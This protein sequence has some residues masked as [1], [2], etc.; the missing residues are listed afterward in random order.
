MNAIAFFSVYFDKDMC[1]RLLNDLGSKIDQ[2]RMAIIW[3]KGT[4]P[5]S[6]SFEK[7]RERYLINLLESGL[8][9]KDISLKCQYFGANY[10]KISN[11]AEIEKEL[12]EKFA[13]LGN[14]EERKT[15]NAKERAEKNRRTSEYNKWLDSLTQDENKLV[16]Y[17]Q[18][19]IELRDTRKD[20]IA[21]FL[22]VVFK[23][24]QKLFREVGMDEKLIYFYMFNEIIR[25]KKYLLENKD[26]LMKRLDGC[27]VFVGYNGLTEIEYGTFETTKS[28]LD[29]FFL[30]Q[31][32][33]F[34][35]SEVIKGQV[36]APGKIKGI[37]KV[38]M[39]LSKESE[40][41]NDGDI[42]VT[43]MTRPEFVPLMK[44]AAAIVTDEGGITCHAAIVSRE[45]GIPC[46][47]GTKVASRLLKDG[48]VI[49]VDAN[50]G[51][52]RILK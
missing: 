4:T 38:V 34:G 45:L 16:R 44:K 50:T 48:D 28:K 5:V 18:K 30:E 12:K 26:V 15:Y 7:R 35:D 20:Y 22:V 47:V 29:K 17:L 2:K 8:S 42:L 32:T 25:G 51:T 19:I 13:W 39:N 1:I 46:V 9:W 40:K 41:F 33:S 49:E 24:A 27:T 11:P 36:G 6:E 23:I 52:V 14:A 3:E 37:A 43:G 31:Q 10:N 21:K